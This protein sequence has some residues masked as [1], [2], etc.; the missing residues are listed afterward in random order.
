MIADDDFPYSFD[1][2][3]SPLDTWEVE[4]RLNYNDLNYKFG[5]F[6]ARLLWTMGSRPTGFMRC[7]FVS[8]QDLVMAKLILHD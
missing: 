5:E 4:S 7:G 3:I 6:S 2:V 8:Y 1:V